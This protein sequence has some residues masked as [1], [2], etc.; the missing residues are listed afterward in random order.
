[1][2]TVLRT[3]FFPLNILITAISFSSNY[4]T[5]FGGRMIYLNQYDLLQVEQLGHGTATIHPSEH[6]TFFEGFYMQQ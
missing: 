2:P 5:V 4:G 1:M 3:E 6:H